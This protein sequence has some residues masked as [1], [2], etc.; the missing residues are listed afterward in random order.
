M[1]GLPANRGILFDH[2]DLSNLADS[3]TN[4]LDEVYTTGHDSVTPVPA[5][6]GG[7]VLPGGPL[8]PVQDV[9][10]V[11]LQVEDIDR[12]HAGLRDGVGDVDGFSP[13][14]V[15][16]VAG[17]RGVSSLCAQVADVNQPGCGS[18]RIVWIGDSGAGQSRV[19]Y[20]EELEFRS[21]EHW[22]SRRI[23]LEIT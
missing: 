14:R 6:P 16:H 15:D 7:G 9:H 11:P 18:S 22:R 20:E 19:G 21:I 13:Q 5:V 4:D 2:Q 3:R 8:A 17:D 23:K 1:S 12:D 10:D